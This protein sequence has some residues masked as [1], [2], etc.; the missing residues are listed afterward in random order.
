MAW[1]P[2]PRALK[3]PSP[4]PW[5]RGQTKTKIVEKTYK[6]RQFHVLR[7]ATGSYT[8]ESKRIASRKL[9]KRFPG[10]QAVKNR[11]KRT[12]NPENRKNLIFPD[13]WPYFFVYIHWN[14]RSSAHWRPLFYAF[15]GY[16]DFLNMVGMPR[17][18]STDPMA[19]H[20]KIVAASGR[21]IG[22]VDQI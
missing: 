4:G 13:F 19:N 17:A 8:V 6:L 10:L 7:V 15:S 14:S 20:V 5:A 12:E 21:M 18:G 22:S 11:S 9:L 2:R 3:G 16:R 1:S